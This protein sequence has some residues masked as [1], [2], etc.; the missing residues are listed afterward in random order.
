M[1][2]LILA[3]IICSFTWTINADGDLR[4]P[5]KQSFKIG[6]D[7]KIWDRYYT[8]NGYYIAVI[9]FS[10]PWDWFM[11]GWG[12]TDTIIDSWVFRIDTDHIVTATD[13]Y[14]PEDKDRPSS[15]AKLGG[16]DDLELLGYLVE[17]DKTT[18]KIRRKLRTGDKYDKALKKADSVIYW[19]FSEQPPGEADFAPGGLQRGRVVRR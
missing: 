4:K 17:D 7:F 3:L 8:K 12:I 15:D 9:E 11:I 10:H 18:V 1:R 5:S 14:W 16:T 13:S 2:F 6:K 19:A